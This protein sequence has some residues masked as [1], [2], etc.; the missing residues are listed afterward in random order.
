M[1]FSYTKILVSGAGL[2]A[3]DTGFDVLRLADYGLCD[4]LM[5]IELRCILTSKW[6]EV[7]SRMAVV[8]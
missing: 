6:P 8:S 1:V 5:L 7:E 3:L 4:C 2:P